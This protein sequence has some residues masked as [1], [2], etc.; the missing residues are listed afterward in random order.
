MST[1]KT[2]TLHPMLWLA[3]ASVTA[4]SLAGVAKLAGV[5]PDFSKPA[6]PASAATNSAGCTS[7]PVLLDQLFLV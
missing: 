6:A 7:W 4:V 2:P 1:H 3:A 5:L